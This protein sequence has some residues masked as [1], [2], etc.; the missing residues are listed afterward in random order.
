MPQPMFP[1]GV[2]VCSAAASRGRALLA[3]L[4][5]EA[6]RLS[7]IAAE[8]ASQS[9]AGGGTGGAGAA[10]VGPAS[11]LDRFS[12]LVV[13]GSEERAEQEEGMQRVQNVGRCRGRFF[14]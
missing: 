5:L 6:P 2:C 11:H 13:G 3:Y 4:E 12:R 8:E 7:L 1:Y 9:A 10:A 14:L